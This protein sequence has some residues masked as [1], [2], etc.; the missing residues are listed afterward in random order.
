MSRH[1]DLY[2]IHSTAREM[3]G[4]A[5]ASDPMDRYLPDGPEGDFCQ[6]KIM[7]ARRTVKG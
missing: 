4:D 1:T 5:G 2:A 7:S 6:A 3:E